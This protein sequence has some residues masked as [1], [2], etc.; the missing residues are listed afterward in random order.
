MSEKAIQ[1]KDLNFTRS[2]SLGTLLD[3]TV[4]RTLKAWMALAEAANL[5]PLAKLVSPY[6]SFDSEMTIILALS[7]WLQGVAPRE[8]LHHLL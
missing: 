5:A 3:Y 6:I 2:Y 7:K 8:Q 1:A 4:Q